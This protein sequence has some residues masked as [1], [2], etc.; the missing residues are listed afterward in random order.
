MSLNADDLQEYLNANIPIT[1]AM[2]VTVADADWDSVRIGAPLA[3]NTNHRDT[4]FGG[5]AAAVAIL[6]AWALLHLRLTSEG[7]D[8]RL[9]IQRSRMRYDRPI[10]G[11]FTATSSIPDAAVWHRFLKMLTQKGRGRLAVPVTVY[12]GEESVAS[13]E[14]EFVALAGGGD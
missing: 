10:D 8:S 13:F 3:P 9:V 4:V 1:R 12:C 2:G 14:V 5:S 6:A 7:I 11:D